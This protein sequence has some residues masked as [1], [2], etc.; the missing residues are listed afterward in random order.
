MKVVLYTAGVI[1]QVSM[2]KCSYTFFLPETE[3]L[4]ETIVTVVNLPH[5]G[6]QNIS[7][8]P[9]NPTG[10]TDAKL[11]TY[12][13]VQHIKVL[14]MNLFCPPAMRSATLGSWR[15]LTQ[16]AEYEDTWAPSPERKPCSGQRAE[17]EKLGPAE[18]TH[19]CTG[20]PEEPSWRASDTDTGQKFDTVLHLDGL[21]RAGRRDG[22]RHMVK[23]HQTLNSTPW[24]CRSDTQPFITPSLNTY[25]WF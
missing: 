10:Q 24:S 9:F 4:F 14:C 21:S 3:A 12:L 13:I 1:W 23:K 2:D 17:D 11:L 25:L 22:V 16:G 6:A 7:H 15:M 5:Q 19:T 8:S 20:D 18:G